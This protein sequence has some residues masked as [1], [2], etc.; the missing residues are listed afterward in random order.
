M[1]IAE[2]PPKRNFIKENVKIVKQKSAITHNDNLS[3]SIHSAEPNVNTDGHQRIA[4]R[5]TVSNKQEMHRSRSLSNA[6]KASHYL[7]LRNNLF[8]GRTS[9]EDIRPQSRD[10]SSQTERVDNELFLKDVII[11]YAYA[12]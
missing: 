12:S 6:R 10:A 3:K 8:N 7:D 4:K 5:R 9:T 1:P 11:R 2:E